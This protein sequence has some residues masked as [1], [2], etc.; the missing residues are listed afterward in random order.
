MTRVNGI[1]NRAGLYVLVK[2]KMN[3]INDVVV[4]AGDVIEI[5]ANSHDRLTNV[6]GYRGQNYDISRV[7]GILVAL[8]IE[9]F[10]LL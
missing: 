1:K 6:V 3:D 8:N 10:L 2:T 4:I 5:N 7:N 9:N